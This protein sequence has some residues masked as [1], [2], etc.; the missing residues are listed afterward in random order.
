MQCPLFP[1][2]DPLFFPKFNQHAA[3]YGY[4]LG[5]GD[6]NLSVPC[7][8]AKYLNRLNRVLAFA[9]A[10]H[11]DNATKFNEGHY[12]HYNPNIGSPSLG[13]D[14]YAHFRHNGQAQFVLLDGHVEA[15]RP[16]GPVQRQRSRLPAGIDGGQRL[17]AVGGERHALLQ[18][19][20]FGAA[21]YRCSRP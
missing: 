13:L 2:D 19:G 17:P 11:F 3:S 10:V 9:D 5:L 8:R 14:G 15:Q 4:N 20:A 7:T 1:Y 18:T 16:A 21:G 6:P 12:I